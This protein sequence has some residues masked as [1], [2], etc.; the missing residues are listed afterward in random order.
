MYIVKV[1]MEENRSSNQKRMPEEQVQ[2]PF[3]KGEEVEGWFR[4][5]GCQ[6]VKVEE[7]GAY[8]IT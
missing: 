7:V 4:P 1:Q 2:S 6:E 5:K 8:D 3:R